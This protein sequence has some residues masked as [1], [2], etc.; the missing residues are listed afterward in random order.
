MKLPA[1][2]HRQVQSVGRHDLG[3][4]QTLSNAVGQQG[5]VLQQG[6]ET[7]SQV[8]E[9]YL[10]RQ[11]NAEYDDQVTSMQIEF[12][13]W[14]SQYGAKDVFNAEDIAESGIPDHLIRRY[15]TTTDDY[16]KVVKTERDNI[17][18][19][20]VYPHLL[21]NKLAGMAA[22]KAEK[23]SNPMLRAEFIRK[24]AINEANL[25]MQASFN[26]ENQQEKF[27]LDKAIF[28]Y[29]NAADRGEMSSALFYIDGMATDDL[30]K[31]KLTEDAIYRVEFSDV[32]GAIRSNDPETVM[33]MRSMLTDPQYSGSLPE[34]Q[35]QAAVGAL[36]TKLKILGADYETEMLQQEG[37]RVIN[38]V[39]GI[40]RGESSQA[41][42]QVL[43]DKYVADSA[44][45]DGIGPKL[46]GQMMDLQRSYEHSVIVEERRIEAENRRIAAE[47]EAQTKADKVLYNKEWKRLNGEFIAVVDEGIDNNQI[48]QTDL[49]RMLADREQSIKDGAANPKSLDGSQYTALR[50][51]ILTRDKKLVAATERFTLGSALI[52]DGQNASRENSAHQDGI[53]EYVK[54]MEIT[55]T[56][57]LVRITQDTNI[58]PQILEDAI[59]HSAL[60][61]KDSEAIPGLV[62]YGAILENNKAG[63]LDISAG[64]RD[65]M[66]TAWYYHR[67]GMSPEEALTKADE[68]A[69]MPEQERKFNRDNYRELKAYGKNM[70][71]LK[72]FMAKDEDTLYPFDPSAVPFNAV[73]D[74][75]KMGADYQYLVAQEY[76]RTGNLDLARS[77]AWN[78]LREVWSPSGVGI[79]MDG[80]KIT[81]SVR[82]DR[83]GV[84]RTL[85]ITTDIAN[86]RLAAFA[87]ENGLEVGTLM[88]KSDPFTAR[89][90]KSWEI[91]QVDPETFMLDRVY[92]ME[93]GETLRWYPDRWIDQGNAYR[94]DLETKKAVDAKVMRKE[95]EKYEPLE[96]PLRM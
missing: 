62:A 27:M 34:A 28:D 90:G 6:M 58:M 70:G 2:Q 79:R 25:N 76:E 71:V 12:N 24:A 82:P 37:I 67:G 86:D 33:A 43:F 44:D 38:L 10:D 72:G 89:D 13:E 1:I 30:H 87:I 8:T 20:E 73:S 3:A 80:I 23:I 88:V 59:V 46:Y 85:G 21:R 35:R 66:N 81:D 95:F 83:H 5:R 17:P 52:K 42:I 7:L 32:S 74:T 55:D 22:D 91:M 26:A 63:L 96:D 18:A 68:I 94:H 41:E 50:H 4:L 48:H 15:D 60:N 53:D 39:E 54:V 57:A 14:N 9:A 61:L 47:Q 75:S 92:D 65:L 45:P 56:G 19:Y 29:Q 78:R 84:E 77:T 16:G 49:E 69:N 64:T 51:H 40:K 11:Q 36:T 31:K 93:S